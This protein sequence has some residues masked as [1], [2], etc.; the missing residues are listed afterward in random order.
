MFLRRCGED[1]MKV[2]LGLSKSGLNA[3]CGV[4]IFY[5]E[6]PLLIKVP[7]EWFLFA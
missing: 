1:G 6:I 4:A 3:G 7:N 5:E 2:A